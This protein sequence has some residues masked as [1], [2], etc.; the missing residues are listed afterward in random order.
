M[1]IALTRDMLRLVL[2][3]LIASSVLTDCGILIASETVTRIES[4][5]QRQLSPIDPGWHQ[6]S[7]FR[8]L[9]LRGGAKSKRV[10]AR[11]WKEHGEHHKRMRKASIKKNR[12]VLRPKH[13][14]AQAIKSLEKYEDE[15]RLKEIE[16]KL[17]KKETHSEVLKN[18]I[19]HHLRKHYMRISEQQDAERKQKYKSLDDYSDPVERELEE[20]RQKRGETRCL[21][22]PDWRKEHPTYWKEVAKLTQDDDDLDNPDK[23]R[24]PSIP[25]RSFTRSHSV[26]SDVDT[27]AS[28]LSG[29]SLGSP[30]DEACVG[31]GC[32]RS[33]RSRSARA[34]APR[35]TLCER[36]QVWKDTFDEGKVW[37]AAAFN[38]R[39]EDQ[40]PDGSA[41]RYLEGV[42]GV[43]VSG[44][45]GG[46]GRLVAAAQAAEQAGPT[47]YEEAP[48]SLEEDIAD[49]Q[50]AAA[51]AA[52]QR[53]AEAVGE[54]EG[55]ERRRRRRR[56]VV[57][58]GEGPDRVLA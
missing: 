5:P 57:R 25:S 16:D 33:P 37:K 28:G 54:A 14:T 40:R 45:G 42:G 6:P 34:P 13:Y 41:T 32:A 18:G 3:V 8:L 31:V 52:A 56:A 4:V 44:G 27:P 7:I 39:M 53:R 17:A 19:A 26:R 49:A 11:S 29:C 51:E 1:M 46:G 48:S 36:A 2:A 58:V 47:V 55:R 21:T 22:G 24:G 43:I 35:L 12:G 30:C 50:Q 38:R 23:V 9:R 20:L 10:R 15:L